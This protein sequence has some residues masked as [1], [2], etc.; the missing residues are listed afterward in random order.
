MPL[1]NSTIET[2]AFELI[3]DRIADILI[4]EIQGQADLGNDIGLKSLYTERHVPVDH[5]K[6]PAIAISMDRVSYDN[7]SR[8]SV[9]GE[10]TYFIDVID[11]SATTATEHGDT[12]AS[13]RIQKIVGIIRMILY[14]PVYETL[15]FEKP[16]ISRHAI[17]EISFGTFQD[18]D[19]ENVQ[20]ARISFVVRAAEGVKFIEPTL[21]YE[22]TTSVRIGDSDSGYVFSG[23]G[24]EE[25]VPT[26]DPSILNIN[27]SEFTSIA[28][29][30]SFDL[31]VR[32]QNGNLVGSQNGE[33]W[34]VDTSGSSEEQLFEYINIYE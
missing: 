15:G 9:D 18:K 5:V 19:Q 31:S 8:K 16:F 34:R 6:L 22:Y 29:G 12:K 27:G 2:Q 4:D 32:D 33:E 25:P 23:S 26:C 10:Y 3:R 7:K 1:I 14:S 30:G 13:K 24:V 21:L 17:T 11:K 20:M 28:S